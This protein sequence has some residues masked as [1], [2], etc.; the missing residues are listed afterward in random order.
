MRKIVGDRVDEDAR[1]FAGALDV[2]SLAQVVVTTEDPAH[3]IENAFDGQHGPGAT[4]WV[5]AGSGRQTVTVQFD[6]PQDIRAVS[7]E[8]EEATT[9]RT[10]E[11]EL[12]VSTDAGASFEVVVRQEYTFSPPG[13]AFERETWSVPR[14]GVT[15][16]RV[17]VRPDKGGG[18]SRARLTAFVIQGT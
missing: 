13:A 15:H 16:V 6:A 17:T 12:S 2:A 3:P 7:V 14:R 10:Q 9:T 11:I 1:S 4:E 18:D 5:A 8:V